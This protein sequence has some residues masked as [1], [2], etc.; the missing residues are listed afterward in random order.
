[1][2][3]HID[4]YSYVYPL[5]SAPTSS[6]A[7][8]TY[9]DFLGQLPQKKMGFGIS[10]YNI[11]GYAITCLGIIYDNMHVSKA[12]STAQKKKHYS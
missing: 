6:A 4:L 3:C 7:F 2:H 10:L 9:F 12:E 1:M 5:K 8:D 11:Q